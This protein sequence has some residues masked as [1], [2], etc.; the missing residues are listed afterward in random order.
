M[1]AALLTVPQMFLAR[2]TIPS[3]GRDARAEGRQPAGLPVRMA[4]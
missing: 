1:G 2:A 4:A 3:S